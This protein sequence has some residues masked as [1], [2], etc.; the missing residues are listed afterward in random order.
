MNG[1]TTRATELT[2]EDRNHLD[3]LAWGHYAVG[4][5][6]LLCGFFPIIHLTVGIGMLTGRMGQGTPTPMG[7]IFV[8]VALVIMGMFWG[9]AALIIY[10]GRCLR[11]RTKRTL[12]FVV[13]VL[14]AAFFQP[15]GLVTGILTIIVLSRPAVKAAFDEDDAIAG[16]R[17]F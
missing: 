15:F 14:Q 17:R 12:V 1:E 8:A 2:E 4:G 6:S 10:A 11:A 7:A 5:L 3:W 9:I 13:A 16:P